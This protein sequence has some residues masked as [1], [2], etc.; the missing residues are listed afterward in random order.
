M[1]ETRKL[2][3]DKEEKILQEKLI[4]QYHVDILKDPLLKLFGDIMNFSAGNT[5]WVK[6]NP[7]ARIVYELLHKYLCT[8]EVIIT[9][10]GIKELQDLVKSQCTLLNKHWFLTA[11]EGFLVSYKVKK[12]KKA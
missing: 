10:E 4:K 11:K 12:A 5:R 3:S 9:P 1:I 6:R 2:L 8:H 7:M